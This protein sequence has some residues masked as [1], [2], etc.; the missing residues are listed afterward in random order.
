M[1]RQRVV[2]GI[3]VYLLIGIDQSM[4]KE[5]ER[6]RERKKRGGGALPNKGGRCNGLLVWGEG[7]QC[8]LALGLADCGEHCESSYQWD[9]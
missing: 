4:G 5:R 2:L 8:T 7:P 1:N 3:T 6:G 9:I